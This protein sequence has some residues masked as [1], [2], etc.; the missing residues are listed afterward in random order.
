M[1]GGEG[2][3]GGELEVDLQGRVG[4][5]AADLGSGMGEA[6][7]GRRDCGRRRGMGLGLGLD[8]ALYTKET[9]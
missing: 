6:G 8:A 2:L 3:G 1:S 7:E 5:G 4:A 9:R